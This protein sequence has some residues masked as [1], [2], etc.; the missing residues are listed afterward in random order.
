METL[1]ENDW[2]LKLL[3]GISFI[4]VTLLLGKVIEPI[5]LALDICPGDYNVLAQFMS[6]LL[7]LLIFALL[8]LVI[9][10][11]YYWFSKEFAIARYCKL[12]L[13]KK[14]LLQEKKKDYFLLHQSILNMLQNN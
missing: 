12:P 5:F 13:T 1:N 14:K 8:I 9:Q 4:A 11:I 10:C 3:F 6:G 7:V 2:I